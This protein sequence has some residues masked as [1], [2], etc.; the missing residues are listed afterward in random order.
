MCNLQ[1]WSS[2]KVGSYFRFRIR[3]LSTIMT[4]NC[5]RY[6]PIHIPFKCLYQFWSCYTHNYTEWFL[7]FFRLGSN[8]SC[9]HVDYS[10]NCN[11]QFLAYV[12]IRAAVFISADSYLVIQIHCAF[13]MG[14]FSLIHIPGL[15]PLQTYLLGK[16]CTCTNDSICLPYLLPAMY[17]HVYRQGKAELIC[18]RGWL[19]RTNNT[20]AFRQF[21]F[22]PT[23]ISHHSCSLFNFDFLT[24][25]FY[26]LC[27]VGV[28]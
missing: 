15:L 20:H 27:C 9:I 25:G 12:M 5:K 7:A 6:I 24:S 28:P 26:D 21:T 10:L 11:F 3:F 22:I 1:S 2:E 23:C 13:V 14:T 16:L 19:K 4:Y 8:G 17:I 18:C